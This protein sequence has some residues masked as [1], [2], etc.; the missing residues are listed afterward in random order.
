[1]RGNLSGVARLGLPPSRGVA[2]T[3]GRPRDT[4]RA[5]S[6]GVARPTAGTYV[7]RV[8]HGYGLPKERLR[9]IDVLTKTGLTSTTTR[10]GMS[11]AAE[12][13]VP[14]INFCSKMPR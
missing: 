7:P 8:T 12:N 3:R 13:G 9:F 10:A 4:P 2:D 11:R 1:M 14:V 6:K 5:T